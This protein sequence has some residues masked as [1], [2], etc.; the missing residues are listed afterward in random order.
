VLSAVAVQHTPLDAEEQLLPLD[1][2]QAGVA[3]YQSVLP[4]LWSSLVD[5]DGWSVEELWQVLSWG[6]SRFLGLDPERLQAGSDRWLLWDPLAP[7]L[8]RPGTLAANRPLALA[9]LRGAMRAA[10]PLP[11]HQWRLDP[12]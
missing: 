7:P 9:G 8:E 10:G 3:G 6:P 11:Q 4:A 12:P 1:Q 5:Q 2:R